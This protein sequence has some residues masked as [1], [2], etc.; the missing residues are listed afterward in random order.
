MNSQQPLLGFPTSVVKTSLC[1]TAVLLSKNGKQ[2]LSTHL[3][4]LPRNMAWDASVRE[5]SP[6]HARKHLSEMPLISSFETALLVTTGRTLGTEAVALALSFVSHLVPFSSPPLPITPILANGIGLA[7]IGRTLGTKAAA[8][9][10]SF[11]SHSVPFF[12]SSSNALTSLAVAVCQL[13]PSICQQ[14]CSAAPSRTLHPR[15]RT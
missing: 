9:A 6:L 3:A 12:A 5:F 2:E 8:D 7:A 11:V 10:L 15:Q 1:A 4:S 13:L 14:L